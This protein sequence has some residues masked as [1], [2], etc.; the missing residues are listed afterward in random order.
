MKKYY[1]FK[2]TFILISSIFIACSTFESDEKIIKDPVEVSLNPYVGRLVTVNALVGDDSLKL[3][4]DTGGGE[5]FI[6]SDVA[7]RLGC[8]PSGRS[9]GFRMNGERVESK[10]CHDIVI[11]I[12]GVSFQHEN[13][14]V[15]NI[16]SV[17]PEDFPPLDGILSLKT[18]LNQPFTLDLSSKHLIFESEESLNERTKTMIKLESRIATGTD[19]SELTVFLHGRI[20]DYGWFLFDSGNLDVFLISHY[21]ADNIQNDSTISTSIWESEFTFKNF[22]TVLTQF[23]TKEI[24]YDGVLSEEFIRK[25]IFTFKLSTN[26][27]WAKPVGS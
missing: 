22:S 4:F 21:F 12:G 25:W 10:Y 1:S 26:S 20:K 15:W 9:I 8:E 5:T 24:I 14:G 2:I 11:S 17:L 3:L 19:G 27:V 18:F 16:N 13:I 6:G 7:R 23:R